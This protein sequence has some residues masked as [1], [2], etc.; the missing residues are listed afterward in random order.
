M[1]ETAQLADT[2]AIELECKNCGA[3]FERSYPPKTV[4]N[5]DKDGVR[6]V[7]AADN[8]FVDSRLVCEVCDLRESLRVKDRYPI[9]EDD[10]DDSRSSSASDEADSESTPRSESTNASSTSDHPKEDHDD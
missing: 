9:E 4:V 3:T 5:D 10:V 6:A 7:E 8:T 1:S 2:F